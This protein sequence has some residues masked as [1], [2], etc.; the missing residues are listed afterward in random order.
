MAWTT[1]ASYAVSEIVTAAKLNTHIRDNL[2]YL[3]GNGGLITISNGTDTVGSVRASGNAS[4]AAGAGIEMVYVGGTGYLLGYDRTAA[5]YRPLIIGG[6]TLE[7]DIGASVGMFMDANRNLGIGTTTPQGRLHATG[8]IGGC[9]FLN[10]A[11]VAGTAVTLAIAGTVQY[12][13]VGKIAI[14]SSA[15]A[16]YGADFAGAGGTL[17][18][19]GA[20]AAF[21]VG[22]DTVTL[23]VTAGGAI[24]VQRTAGGN[25]HNISLFVVYN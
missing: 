7:F 12:G 4:P 18:V 19:P 14:R 22:A 2:D 3:K 8:T 15:A 5:G 23:A 24:T 25:T 20:S 9:V 6:T 17:L 16:T 11:T 1:P 13:I 10:A 21:T